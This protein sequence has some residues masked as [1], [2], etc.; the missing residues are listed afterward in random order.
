MADAKTIRMLNLIYLET[1]SRRIR[2]PNP[3]QFSFGRIEDTWS[4]SSIGPYYKEYELVEV[5]GGYYR[6][7]EV[8]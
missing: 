3:P 2:L 1:G 6:W 8:E 5:T 7:K 4:P